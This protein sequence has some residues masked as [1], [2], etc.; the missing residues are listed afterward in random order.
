MIKEFESARLS[1][2]LDEKAKPMKR[3]INGLHRFRE[4]IFPERREFF[5]HLAEGQSPDFLFIACCDSRIQPEVLLQ[6]NPGELFILRNIG[7]LVPPHGADGSAEAAVEYA[8]RALGVKHIIICGHSHCG[9]MKAVLNPEQLADLPSVATWLRH[10]DATRRII[11][12]NYP[13]L[14][15][16][17]RLD[18]AIEENVL[19]QLEH[20]M[21]LPSVAPRL[22]RGE[23]NL[24]GWVYRFE[25][26]EVSAY[27]PEANGFIEVEEAHLPSIRPVHRT[28]SIPH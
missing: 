3:L 23:L 14:E 13:H 8:I 22:M 10:A 17:A 11:E 16:E 18:K 5:E 2:L 25:T 21:T 19:V 12:E 7:N 20:L 4:G 1:R 15:G 9:A 24:H 6:T 26:G 27:D 28:E